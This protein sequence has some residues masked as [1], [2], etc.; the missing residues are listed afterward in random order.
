MNNKLLK[1]LISQLRKYQLTTIFETPEQLETW[2]KKIPGKHITNLI[3]LNIDP[4]EIKFPKELLINE[5]LLNCDD[6]SHRVL[7]MSTLKNGDG[8]WHL[9]DRLCSPN[10]L[11]SKFYYRDIALISQAQTARYALWVIDNAEFIN[12]K[13]HTEDLQL[14]IESLNPELNNDILVA[15]S[16]ATVASD[17]NSLNSQYHRQDMEL[18]FQSKGDGLQ[19]YGSYPERGVNNLAK[20][21]VS[22][23]DPYHLE[24]MQ[25][26][27]ESPHTAEFLYRLMTDS[28]IV[29]GK[30]YRE[31]INALRDAKSTVTAIA[32]YYYITNPHDNSWYDISTIDFYDLDYNDDGRDALNYCYRCI[33]R[34]N[35]Q[36]GHHNPKYLEYLTLLNEIDD[37]VV[38][39]FESL[40]SDNTLINSEYYE[41]DL[42]L[43]LEVTNPRIYHDLYQLM[44]NKRS[45]NSPHH[46]NDAILI[47]K[48]EN[49]KTRRLLLNKATNQDSLNNPNHEYDMKYISK[50]NLSKIKDKIY[51]S[52]YYYLFNQKG[53]NAY[54]HIDALEKLSKGEMYEPVNA[55]DEYLDTLENHL[56]PDDYDYQ[57]QDNT[58][59]P[60]MTKEKILTRIKKLFRKKN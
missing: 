53:M 13:Y 47:S 44:T 3:S 30:Y 38:P 17:K 42:N 8:C 22:L 7:A 37:K 55:I 34:K 60:M 54:E 10:F 43:L 33:G 48:T 18:I 31:E 21:P 59:V 23:Q 27:S 50:L 26:L 2:L 51:D 39:Y 12:S 11:N 28:T 52:M 49:E 45:L 46:L 15:E 40:L 5:N 41:H 16:L 25:I 58:P 6:Y 56:L 36:P 24:N 57:E 19:S 9:F 4:E 29:S 20:N 35:N 14:I 1:K 32:M